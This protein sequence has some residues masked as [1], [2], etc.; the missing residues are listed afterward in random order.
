[1]ITL[2]PMTE[3]DFA[4]Y[5]SSSIK[6]YAVEKKKAG[7]WTSEE[8]MEKSA[9]E[10]EKLLPEGLD[11]KH[12]YL[13]AVCNGKTSQRMGY[14][15]YK[16]DDAN[17]QKEAFIYDFVIFEDS[18]GKGIGQKVLK[19]MDEIAAKRGIKKIS[20]HVFAHNKAAIRLYEKT[21]FKTTDLLMS[22][23]INS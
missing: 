12:Q 3:E 8:A 16:F 4:D 5:T 23:Y 15:W 2:V 21:N 19:I 20:L 11:T 9:A 1:M 14:F 22:K 6:N 13:L 18:R 10:F 7:T 17:S